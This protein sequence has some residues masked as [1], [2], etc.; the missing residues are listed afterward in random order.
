M[1]PVSDD[2][3]CRYLAVDPGHATGWAAFDH[4][5]QLMKYGTA[6]TKEDFYD[7]LE[8]YMPKTLIVENFRLVPWKAVDQSWSEFKT[9]KIIG[10]CELFAFQ[11]HAEVIMQEPTIKVMGYKLAMIPVPK[12]HALSHET[13][14]YVHGVYYLVNNKLMKDA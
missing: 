2:R 9:V 10:A 14:A 5:G 8:R 1:E 11:T 6:H 12:N 13:D 4:N 7:V 3:D